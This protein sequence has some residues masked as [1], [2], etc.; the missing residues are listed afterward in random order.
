[1]RALERNGAIEVALGLVIIA[2]VG[3]LGTIAPA[4]H[5]QPSWPFAI[6][7]SFAALS[8]STEWLSLV[9]ALEACAVAIL[10]IIVGIFVRHLRWPLF[11]IG[12][13]ALAWWPSWTV[14]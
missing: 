7:V 9:I 12:A 14:T 3:A 5:D 10:M 8:D 6:Q 13:I 4:V 11:A 2:I 1:L